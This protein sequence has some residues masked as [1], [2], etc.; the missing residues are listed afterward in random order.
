MKQLIKLLNITPHAF[1]DD[2]TET[3]Y[4]D[5]ATFKDRCWIRLLPLSKEEKESSK[6]KNSRPS[7]ITGAF[8]LSPNFANLRKLSERLN[9][10][11]AFDLHKK[12]QDADRIIEPIGL[13]TSASMEEDFLNIGDEDL[14]CTVGTQEAFDNAAKKPENFVSSAE[15]AY[16]CANKSWCE[17]DYEDIDKTYNALISNCRNFFN[18]SPTLDIFDNYLQLIPPKSNLND[19]ERWNRG[20]G[21]DE[22]YRHV[23]ELFNAIGSD[24]C[25][26]EVTIN[27]DSRCSWGYIKDPKGKSVAESGYQHAEKFHKYFTSSFCKFDGIKSIKFREWNYVHRRGIYSS[28]LGGV[29]LEFGIQQEVNEKQYFYPRSPS[30]VE[31]IYNLWDIDG[32][33]KYSLIDDCEYEVY[34]KLKVLEL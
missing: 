6:N 27:K 31:E 21:T 34:P 2:C 29:T 20:V 9:C 7:S 28:K 32:N 1:L 23:C 14:N 12:M 19:L 22:K 3:E 18:Y 8:L 25:K 4:V 13:C 5:L 11:Y 16:D 10:N 17:S 24:Q 30:Q 33:G 26:V 15:V